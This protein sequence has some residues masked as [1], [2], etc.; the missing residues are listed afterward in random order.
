VSSLLAVLHKSGRWMV[1]LLPCFRLQASIDVV[2]LNFVPIDTMS[3]EFLEHR[4]PISLYDDEILLR[5]VD[6]LTWDHEEIQKLFHQPNPSD[7]FTG[8]MTLHFSIY[9]KW[10][11]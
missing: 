1:F 9:G 8:S 6:A 11:S 4:A 10:G 7:K 3:I 2:T 5:D